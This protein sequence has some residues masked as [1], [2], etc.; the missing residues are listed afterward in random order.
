MAHPIRMKRPT[1]ATLIMDSSK[2]DSDGTTSRPIDQPADQLN[3]VLPQAAASSAT[4]ACGRLRT[5]RSDPLQGQRLAEA[6]VVAFAYEY[7][8]RADTHV[9]QRALQRAR[10]EQGVTA[11]VAK[12][13]LGRA[14]GR[15]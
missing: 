9:A 7:V 2:P 11:A 14:D 5:A 10:V 12:G 6:F 15:V 4:K 8:L 13:D 3:H 1:S